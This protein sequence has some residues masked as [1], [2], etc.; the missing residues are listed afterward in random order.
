MIE[1]IVDV[2]IL[3]VI[4]KNSDTVWECQN[5]TG[6]DIHIG[7]PTITIL[8]GQRVLIDPRDI[9]NYIYKNSNGIEVDEIVFLQGSNNLLA[10]IV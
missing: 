10:L 7:A 6:K 3:T 4:N 8:N 5:N 2:A 1:S 9:P